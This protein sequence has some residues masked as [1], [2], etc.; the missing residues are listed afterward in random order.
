M[1]GAC[2]LDMSAAFDVVDHE[3]L[4]EK[5]T[6]YGLDENSIVWVKS[7]LSGRSQSVIV[8]GTLSRLLMVNNGVPQGSILGPL[9]Y[10]LFTNELPEIIHD[11]P[12]HLATQGGATEQTWPA[13]KVTSEENGAICCYADDTTL[14]ISDP[15]PNILSA[16]LTAKYQV[17][18]KFMLNNRLRL[19]DD[20]T[21]LLVMGNCQ[22]RAQ[23]SIITQTEVISPSPCEKLLGCWISRN[24][25]WTEYIREN[26]DNLIKSLNMRLGA[27]KKFRFL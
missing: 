17:I 3:L 7:Y 14:S 5:L 6:L 1:S 13:Y 25:S 21:H 24:M 19:N 15:D 10:T 11:D 26:K 23:I 22:N 18:S 2:F 4:L 9:F 12:L 8:E 20:K 27:I 16:K